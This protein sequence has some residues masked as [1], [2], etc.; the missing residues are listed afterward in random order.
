MLIHLTEATINHAAAVPNPLDGVVPDFNVLGT[1]FNSI[2]KKIAG[3]LWAL[4]LIISIFYLGR[5]I[6]TYAQEQGVHPTQMRD[7]KREAVRAAISLACLVALPVIV[8]VILA[9]VSQ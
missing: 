6:L 9:L 5:G 2:W 3:G 8:G 7:A 4:A 1:Q